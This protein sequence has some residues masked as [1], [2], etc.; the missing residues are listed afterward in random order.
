[1]AFNSSCQEQ[2]T[3]DLEVSIND[4]LS[5]T[6]VSQSTFLLLRY[7]SYQRRQIPL[8]VDILEK[9]EGTEKFNITMESLD[10]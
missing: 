1:M 7:L 3:I 10:E 5:E 8:T 9:L 6:V 2:K 4:H